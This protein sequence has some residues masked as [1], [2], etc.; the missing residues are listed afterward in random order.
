MAVMFDLAHHLFFVPW[1]D[2]QSGVTSFIL[3]ERV[4]PV[5]QSFYFTNASVSPD[6]RWLW[7]Y[8]AAPP[9]PQS[10]LGVVS[11]DPS[12]PMIRHFPAAGFTSASPMV[13]PAGEEPGCYL[14]VGPSVWFQPLDGEARVVCTLG[15]DFVAGRTL[16]RLATHLTLSADGRLFLLDGQVGNSYFIALGDRRSGQVRVVKELANN[17]NHG[18][19]SPIHPELFTVAHDHTHD[20][21]TGRRLHF[22]NRIWLLDIH[23]SRY[24]GLTPH[25]YCK[26]HHA[27]AHEWWSRDGWVCYVDYDSGAYELDLATRKLQHVWPTPLCHVHCDHL[28]PRRWWC[29]DESPYKW[30]QKP[31]EVRFF[32]RTTGRQAQIVSAMPPPPLPRKSYHLDPH[33]QFSPR[34]SWIVYTT[35]V[36][37]RVDVALCPVEALKLRTA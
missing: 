30:D 28:T 9:N 6:E 20:P 22:D 27:I 7:F 33:P 3:N 18:Q 19:F 21:I 26:P 2:P 5:Q 11:L 24:E 31:C 34:D 15:D 36:R 1:T 10:T 14:A 8:C 25:R 29:A 37:G 32:D 35:T 13:S 23:D 4:A 17:H 16:F 12:R